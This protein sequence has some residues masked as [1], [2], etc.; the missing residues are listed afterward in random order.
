MGMGGGAE[1]GD[2]VVIGGVPTRP[3]SASTTG[4]S[5]AWDVS[6]QT[7]LQFVPL[8]IFTLMPFWLCIWASRPSEYFVRESCLEYI[9]HE[10]PLG[11]FI[12]DSHFTAIECLHFDDGRY[13]SGYIC[14]NTQPRPTL[15]VFTWY[16]MCANAYAVY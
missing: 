10:P 8:V 9:A 12:P 4:Q 13:L 15:C 11:Y 3:S 1:E 6:R 16:Q 14:C 7:S 2:Q 5:N